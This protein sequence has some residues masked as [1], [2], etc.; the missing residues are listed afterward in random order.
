[1]QHN[2]QTDLVA[3]ALVLGVALGEGVDVQVAGHQ[4]AH[5]AGVVVVEV[6][7]VEGAVD[8]LA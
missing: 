3:G 4:Q 5:G 8:V 1:M 2:R 6:H 7:V